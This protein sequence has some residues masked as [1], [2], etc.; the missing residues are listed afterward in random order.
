MSFAGSSSWPTT[1]PR[2]L[3]AA[4]SHTA[5]NRT[6]SGFRNTLLKLAVAD[7]ASSR[8]RWG[9]IARGY[10]H[11]GRRPGVPSSAFMGER[12]LGLRLDPECLENLLVGGCATALRSGADFPTPAWPR[13]T[14]TPN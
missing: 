2:P 9:E 14:S 11:C 6:D 12:Q 4:W 1:P 10:R 8:T 3:V 5:A 13:R 7:D